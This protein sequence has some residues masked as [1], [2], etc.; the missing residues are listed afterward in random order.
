MRQ[1]RK[2][3][4]CAE[5]EKK[6]LL[7]AIFEAQIVAFRKADGFRVFFKQ[8][9]GLS[10]GLSCAT[11]VAN[12][13]LRALDIHFRSTFRH[14]LRLYLRFID[15]VFTL[16]D[17][18]CTADVLADCLNSWDPLLKVTRDLGDSDKRSTFLDL[19]VDISGGKLSY[20]TYRKPMNTYQYL[21]YNSCHH[22]SSK[23]GIFRTEL[24]RFLITNSTVD[25]FSFQA[26]FTMHK[27][28]LRGYPADSL[29]KI[30]DE[31]PWSQKQHI[32]NR[33]AKQV[34]RKVVPFKLAFFG[35]APE[36]KLG[37]ILGRAKSLL[38]VDFLR[39]HRIVACFTVGKN[40][41]RKRYA[42]FV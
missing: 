42:R 35:K 38:P 7:S 30:L 34:K 20:C 18:T 11:Q 23:L 8:T 19:D 32:L 28:I 29:F 24:H 41:F 39:N 17:H 9:V 2:T 14:S 4:T 33:P 37:S 5:R 36:L 31:F 27:L 40:L 21:P 10:M 12:I 26:H 25:S 13:F 16:F 3:R 15:D 1:T 6:K 22:E